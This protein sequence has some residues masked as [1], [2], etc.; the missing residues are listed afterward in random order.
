M[1][2]RGAMLAILTVGPSYGHQLTAEIARRTGG[3]APV[4]G[5]QTHATLERLARDGLVVLA[6]KD[7]TGIARVELTAAG[8]RAAAAWLHGTAD[9]VGRGRDD[10]AVRIAIAASLPG[11]DVTGIIAAERAALLRRRDATAV[12]ASPAAA[13]MLARVSALIAADLAWLDEAAELASRIEPTGLAEPPPRGR[14]RAAPTLTPQPRRE[15]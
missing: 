7:T 11:V 9:A 12:A 10:L 2:V 14:R 8:R 1:T 4:N 3:L 6:P 5:G 15:G 13:L